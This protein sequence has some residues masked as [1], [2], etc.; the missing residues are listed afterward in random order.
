MSS[1]ND[2][3]TKSQIYTLLDSLQKKV[4]NNQNPE[5][6]QNQLNV[7]INVFKSFGVVNNDNEL[8]TKGFK[9]FNQPTENKNTN[10]L[11]QTSSSFPKT[12]KS[13]TKNF[14]T[15]K[16]N[17]QYFS[18]TT[19]NN[20]NN[21]NYYEIKNIVRNEFA[22]LILSYQKD[23][24]N[25]TKYLENKIEDTES[26]LKGVIN[27]KSLDNLNETAQ[28][29]NTFLN[30]NNFNNNFDNFN[31]FNNNSI[32][33]NL[34]N[35]LDLISKS[36]YD[37]KF[38]EIDRQM[39]S[40]NSLMKTLKETFDTNMFDFIKYNKIKKDQETKNFVEQEFFDNSI[41]EIINKQN[42]MFQNFENNNRNVAGK[43]G[44]LYNNVNQLKNEN[45]SIDRKLV[46]INDIRNE[47]GKLN[48]EL[49]GI[50]NRINF[51]LLDNLNGININNLKN[52]NEILNLKNVVDNCEN[53]LNEIR[54]VSQDNN[55][56]IYDTKKKMETLEQEFSYFK[57]NLRPIIDINIQKKIG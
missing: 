38:N 31:K 9:T 55:K 52:I 40:M 41:N 12:F 37:K 24:I 22:D 49:F 10:Q 14:D 39:T 13:T 19:Q 56:Y 34:E 50:K 18:N 4:N 43:I 48:E 8:N 17:Y 21:L 51:S 3:Y 46:E 54:S 11:Y 20:F 23:L 5:N 30:N 1:I 36:N 16:N 32:N 15:N 47:L 57:N 33:N 42:N 53:N 25:N 44:D 35:K 27:S 7:D 2:S 45:E 26:K 6:N 28:M 29:L